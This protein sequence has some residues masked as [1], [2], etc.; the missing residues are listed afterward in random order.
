MTT[1][2]F[3]RP[4]G[5]FVVQK[6]RDLAEKNPDFRYKRPGGGG[7][8]NVYDG[9][10]SCIVGQGLIAA[11]VPV[12]DIPEAGGVSSTCNR[13]GIVLTHA[14]R[15]WLDNVQVQQDGG[16]PWGVAIATADRQAAIEAT[17]VVW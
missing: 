12:E 4:N 6:V 16:E 3:E 8:Y 13:L 7:C 11:G 2:T 9:K 10:G 17:A 14:Q 1:T 5:A 15:S